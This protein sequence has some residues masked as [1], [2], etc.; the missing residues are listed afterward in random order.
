MMGPDYVDHRQDSLGVLRPLPRLAAA[1]ERA[2]PAFLLGTHD[3]LMLDCARI[4]QDPDVLEMRCDISSDATLADADS[5][6]RTSMIS[7]RP[8]ARPA[9]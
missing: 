2:D 7:F 6:R 4:M 8:R 5:S 9:G 1:L 3:Q